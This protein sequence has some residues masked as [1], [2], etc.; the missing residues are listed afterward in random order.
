MET[1]ELKKKKFNI[2][3][4]CVYTHVMAFQV[5]SINLSHDINSK[6]KCYLFGK[7]SAL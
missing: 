4:K 2:A 3:K 5:I 6:W 7:K 1:N